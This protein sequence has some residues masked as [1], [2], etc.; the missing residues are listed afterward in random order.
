MR[1]LII[2][3]IAILTSCNNADSVNNV[4][5]SLELE[6]K[7]IINDSDSISPIQDS[8]FTLNYLQDSID[9][10]K[11]LLLA[12]ND[13][14]AYSLLNPFEWNSAQEVNYINSEYEFGAISMKFL[15]Q[16]LEGDSSKIKNIET[17]IDSTGVFGATLLIVVDIDEKLPP[18]GIDEDHIGLIQFFYFVDSLKKNLPPELEYYQMDNYL[19]FNSTLSYDMSAHSILSFKN[20]ETTYFLWGLMSYTPE[21]C[22]VNPGGFHFFLSAFNN[23][24]QSNL[25]YLGRDDFIEKFSFDYLNNIIEIVYIRQDWDGI[26]HTNDEYWDGYDTYIEYLDTVSIKAF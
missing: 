10:N 1:Y 7:K 14:D 15:T 24:K 25:V 2:I 19:K 9:F 4:N 5:K 17:Y 18:K 12:K 20:K 23:V 3:F 8:V 26:D 21:I 13:F 22:D 6:A 16:I 11:S